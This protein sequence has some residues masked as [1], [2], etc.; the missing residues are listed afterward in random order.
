MR[1]QPENA[2]ANQ[3]LAVLLTFEGRRWESVAPLRLRLSDPE[4]TLEE[5]V[6][7]GD[8]NRFIN[9][10]QCWQRCL[11]VQPADC[12]PRIAQARSAIQKNS[13]HEAQT[14]LQAIVA[15]AGAPDEA[16]VWL[17]WVLLQENHGA[18]FN[19][20]QADLPTTLEA[21]PEVWV[22]R[23]LWRQARADS[24]A[25]ARCFWQ[26]LRC[27]PNQSAATY[28]LAGLLHALGDD[29]AASVFRRRDELLHQLREELTQL[30]PIRE[31]LAQVKSQAPRLHRIA[32]TLEKLERLPEAAAW[33]RWIARQFPHDVAARVAAERLKTAAENSS[34]QPVDWQLVRHLDQ[35]PLPKNETLAIANTGHPDT[36]APGGAVRFTD[37][38]ASMGLQFEYFSGYAAPRPGRTL[39]EATGGGVLVLDYDNDS[40][41]D[42]YL[43]Q[44][45]QWPPAAGQAKHFD[46]LFRNQQGRCFLPVTEATG[47][48]DERF[49]QG[50]AVGD[51]NG[52]GFADIYV[53]N[54]DKNRLYRNNGDGTFSDVTDAA[55]ISGSIWTTSA[56]LADLN[57]DG[58][59]DIYDATYVTGPGFDT[60]LC[61]DSGQ[62]RTCPPH[63]FAAAT[64]RLWLNLGDGRFQDHSGPAK[65][66]APKGY[67][68]GVAAAD[69]YGKGMLDIFVAN[70]T[71]ANFFFE[72]QTPKPGAAPRFEE[73]AVISGVAFDS[74]GRA[75]ACMGV[76]VG[77]ANGDGKLDMFVT[78]F[79]QESNTLYL[80]DQVGFIDGTSAAGLR[81]PGYLMMGFGTQFLDADL[82][83]WPDLIVTN[84]HVDDY[85]FK[86]IPY[87]MPAQFFR[88]VGAG[89]FEEAAAAELGPFFAKKQLGRGL[90]RLDWNRDGREDVVISHLDGPAALLTNQTLHTGHFLALRLIGVAS[91][92]DAIGAQVVIRCGGRDRMRQLTAGDGY[93]ASNQRQLVFGLGNSERIEKLS[94]RWPSG[95]REEFANVAAD[96]EYT[97]VEGG[98]KLHPRPAN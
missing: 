33:R 45:C 95:R 72:N 76:A 17:G 63:A 38:A 37:D 27:D 58:W 3:Q 5:L 60:Q 43:T 18:E 92:R 41:P 73:R 78:N 25:A 34:G 1:L 55:G 13:L 16:R 59:P 86:G 61:G 35:L 65:I 19:R 64:D 90:A 50:G 80:Q 40:W 14:I 57:A 44:G 21:H 79:Y 81:D 89:R 8:V 12:G 85:T 70:D 56:L 87:Q 83:G 53:A 47:L 29:A 93:Q 28:Q 10:R 15:E 30:F 82:D 24:P 26:A 51:Y 71:T 46:Q 94:I 52:D 88:N 74:E 96:A 42:I 54:V 49:S 36:S 22:L 77:D 62:P 4:V 7:L 66:I 6:L 31:N 48:G 68:L 98:G 84:G 11:E 20:W 75:Q 67:G 32:E 23:G 97:V 39:P 9:F 2:L 91:S 69:F